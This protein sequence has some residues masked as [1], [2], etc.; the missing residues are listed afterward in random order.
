MY[1][2]IIMNIIWGSCYTVMKWGLDYFSPM[3]LL[4]LRMSIALVVMIAI[5]IKLFKFLDRRVMLRGAFLGCIIAVSHILGF[6]GINKSF[7]TDAA[8]I[9]AVE[10]V[11]AI[12]VARIVLK[13]KMDKWRWLAL[14]MALTGFFILSNVSFHN[15]FSSG[16]FVGNLLMLIGVLADGFYSPIA[17]PVSEKYPARLILTIAL[18]FTTIIILPFAISSPIKSTVISWQG[19]FSVLY[20]SL[21]CTCCGWTLWL[22]F[23]GKFPVNVVALTVF[24][25]PVVGAFVPHFTIGEQIGSRIWFGGGVILLGVLITVFKRKKSNEELIAEGVLH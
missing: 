5:S 19:I 14:A 23:L 25:Q 24:I 18:F 10:P 15:F 12:V 20:L 6:V 8:I 11:A 21:L 9:Y 3:H 7:A 4:F 22:Y 13:E 2:L 16:I 17:K 1:L